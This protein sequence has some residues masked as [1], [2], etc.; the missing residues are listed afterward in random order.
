MEADK[1]KSKIERKYILEYQNQMQIKFDE[2]ESAKK[3]NLKQF[4]D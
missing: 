2:F 4:C 1:N 3:I